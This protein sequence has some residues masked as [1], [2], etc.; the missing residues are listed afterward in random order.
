M[1]GNPLNS[2]ETGSLCSLGGFTAPCYFHIC[3]LQPSHWFRRMG[4]AD[5]CGI[6]NVLISSLLLGYCLLARN[7]PSCYFKFCRFIRWHMRVVRTPPSQ[8]ISVLNCHYLAYVCIWTSE[9]QLI[10][11]T[12]KLMNLLYSLGTYL[13]S[14]GPYSWS[15]VASSCERNK[16]FWNHSSWEGPCHISKLITVN[17]RHVGFVLWLLW[18]YIKQAEMKLQH[19]MYH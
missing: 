18:F 16:V 9:L 19:I 12:Q 2:R 4:Y 8:H 3:T 15:R 13:V 7:H 14:K 1:P 6:P 11:R 10:L 17:S 5:R